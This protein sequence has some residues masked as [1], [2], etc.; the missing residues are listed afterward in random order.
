MNRSY[1]IG[2]MFRL[3]LAYKDKPE[4]SKMRPIVIV[5]IDDDDFI[6]VKLK[7]PFPNW[8]KNNLD[9]DSWF[10]NQSFILSSKDFEQLEKEYLGEI[11]PTD[12]YYI[13]RQLDNT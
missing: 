1:N 3:R 12:Y 10:I 4:Q 5:D 11:T 13:L 9:R 8:R 6:Y 7:K 2:D